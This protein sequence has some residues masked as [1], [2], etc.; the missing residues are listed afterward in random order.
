ML[1]S[2]GS[3]DFRRRPAV[4]GAEDG[5]ATLDALGRTRYAALLRRWVMDRMPIGARAAADAAEWVRETV[6]KAGDRADTVPEDSLLVRL[7]ARLMADR[8]NALC[9]RLADRALPSSRVGV[10]IGADRLDAWE[11]ALDA[12]PRRQRELVILR[13][14]FGLDD[15]AI[16]AE[17][18]MPVAIARAQTVNA[19]AA[20]IDVLGG[21][22]RDRA[23]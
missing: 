5:R 8:R 13:S 19:L 4:R 18:G 6:A 14:E 17:T 3:S 20:L 9:A 2:H 1:S 11:R 16:A 21:Q 15:A 10:L 22:H 7:R 23:A 12:L